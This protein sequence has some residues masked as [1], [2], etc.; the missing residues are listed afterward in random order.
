MMRHGLGMSSVRNRY[1]WLIVAAGL[2]LSVALVLALA[3]ASPWPSVTL[4]WW[5]TLAAPPILYGFLIRLSVRRVSGPRWIGATALLWAVH[6]LAGVL[7]EAAIA[8]FHPSAV[9]PASIIT[10]PPGLLPQFLWIPLVLIPLRHV[11][12]GGASRRSRGRPASA[13]ARGRVPAV[14]SAGAAPVRPVT[15][16]PQPDAASSEPAT[17]DTRE[18]PA[19]VTP[20]QAFVRQA[21]SPANQAVLRPVPAAGGVTAVAEAAPAQQLFEKMLARE[22]SAEVLRVP[23]D[24]IAAQLPA[25]AFKLPLERMAANLLEPEYLLIPQ[26]LVLAQ[27]ADGQVSARWEVVSEQFPRHLLALTDEEIAGQIPGGQLVLPLDELLPQL[28]PELFLPTGPA[29]DLDGIESF[30]APFQPFPQEKR[31]GSPAPETVSAVVE[32]PTVTEAPPVTASTE[33]DVEDEPQTPVELSM[34]PELEDIEA[35]PA[36]MGT[37]L[38]PE[39]APIDLSEAET[40]V[41]PVLETEPWAVDDARGGEGQPHWLETLPAVPTA[42]EV[43]LGSVEAPARAITPD[44]IAA[45]LEVTAGLAPLGPLNVGAESVDGV[46]LF[47]ACS[48]GLPRDLAVTA[49]RLMLPVLDDGRAPWAMEQ[50]TL[51]GADAALVLT[52]LSPVR[53]GGPVLVT[54][55]PSRGSLAL[56]ELLCRRAAA[57]YGSHAEPRRERAEDPDEPDLLDMEPSTR[58]R[59]IAS[60]LGAVGP[61][62]ASALRDAEAEYSLYLFLPAGSDVRAVAGFAYDLGRTMRKA[63]EAGMAFHSAVLGCGRRRMVLH[64]EDYTASRTT[65]IIV[66]AGETDRPG[67][68]YRQVKSATMT[69]GAA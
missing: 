15:T 43:G 14:A 45:A 62:M 35:D 25:A 59:Q 11:L 50:L 1:S 3:V 65:T 56:L 57:R 30:P 10:F 63:G 44:D 36:L 31:G 16:S 34:V 69:L 17:G 40:G 6:V 23:F 39:R 42:D 49:A 19:E 33:W 28:P 48:P 20:R 12:D 68:A 54:A 52:P 13:P 8:S 38:D 7:T 24:R 41:M 32:V 21:E 66:V 60:S 5:L 46:T 47:T 61:V 18:R 26:H 64:R 29:V 37:T 51:R 53:H 55:L 22:T 67:L 4:P 9:G 58:V 27:L 2:V